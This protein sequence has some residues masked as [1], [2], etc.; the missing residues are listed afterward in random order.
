[1]NQKGAILPSVIVFVFLL[2]AVSMGTTQIYKRQM[3]QLKATED[4]YIVQSMIELSKAE[5]QYQ[6]KSTPDIQELFLTYA[7]GTVRVQKTA[8]KTYQ[9]TGISNKAFLKQIS[10]IV[11]YPD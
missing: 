11:D 2:S 1:M 10:I 9:F 4:Y 7:A 8:T 3:Q 5:L 6:L